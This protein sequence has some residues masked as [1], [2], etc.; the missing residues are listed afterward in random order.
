MDELYGHV[1]TTSKG[2]RGTHHNSGRTY[3]HP[4][5]STLAV[6]PGNVLQLDQTG[7]APY[8]HSVM[9]VS[10]T[11]TLGHPENIYV[12]QH[13]GDYGWRQLLEAINTNGCPYVRML[14]MLT[15]SFNS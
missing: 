6:V 10:S 12:G 11:T 2:P 8:Y 5:G 9:V 14:R 15:G 3:Y 13:S 1:Q 4:E 7:V